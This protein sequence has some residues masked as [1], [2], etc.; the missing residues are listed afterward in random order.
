MKIE[1]NKAE[2]LVPEPSAFEF[3]IVT[4]KIKI[5]GIFPIL[6]ELIKAGYRTIRFKVD[7]LDNLFVI[8]RNCSCNER[9]Q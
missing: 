7:E 8:G 5:T 1:M 6:A 9:F 2:P 4:E 3:G